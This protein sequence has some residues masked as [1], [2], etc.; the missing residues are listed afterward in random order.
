MTGAP[1]SGAPPADE[2]EAFLRARPDVR[3]VDAIIPDICGIPRGK[4]LDVSALGKLYTTG[5]ALPGSTYAMDMMGNNVDG[6]GMG[7]DDGDPDHLCHAV[8]GTLAPTP[9]AGPERAQVLMSMSDDDGS[10]WWL[11]PRH[12]ARRMADRVADLGY[13]PVVAVELEF[14]LVEAG[15]GGDGRPAL[16]RSPATGRRPSETQVYL[17]DEMDA[18][19]PVL[20]EMTATC[21]AQNIPADVATVEYAP[22]QFEINLTHTDDPVAACDRA[23][24]LKRA[25]KGVAGKHGMTATFM[26]RPF[27]EHAASGTHVHLSLLDAEGRNAFDDGSP[28]GGGPFRHAIGGLAA[29]MAEAMPIWAPNA[30]SFRRVAPAGWVPL[31]PTWGYNNRTVALRVPG[32]PPASRRIE[33]RAAGADANPYLVVAA[34]LAGVHHG[35]ANRI[36]PGDPVEGDAAA[37]VAPSLPSLH[38]DALRAHAAAGVLPDYFGRAWWDVH[39][40]LKWAEFH[41]FNGHVT[42]LEYDRLLTTI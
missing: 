29:T 19:A 15:A 27:R 24:L 8:P 32:G 34:V 22:G 16:A 36:D 6:S 42:A 30:N 14:Y 28:L 39:G 37:K 25:I 4:R 26:A 31:A 40:K 5:M 12:I 33:H 35:V 1:K 13:R 7:Q 10:P 23:M 38:V 18:Y 41:E 2:A 9:W 21:R 20:D 11:D 3:L 17:M